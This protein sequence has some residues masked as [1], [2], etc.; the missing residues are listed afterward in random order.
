MD[1]GG[2][3][4]GGGGGSSGGGRKGKEPADAASGS[5][6]GGKARA[7]GVPLRTPSA[8]EREN[9]RQRERR[10]RSVAANI[11]FGLRAYG[12]YTLPRNC[13]NNEVL[14]A[15]CREAGWV[16]E[17]DGT[18]YRRVIPPANMMR[19]GLSFTG[20]APVSPGSSSYPITPTSNSR[21]ASSSS[22]HRTLAGS[23]F[24]GG[25]T[26]TTR[27]GGTGTPNWYKRRSSAL[28]CR[29]REGERV[30]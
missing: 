11:Y 25:A 5:G 9:N 23:L 7:R 18:T 10:R 8:E 21:T 16:V 30:V 2:M 27:G 3:G 13:D 29:T 14:K 12:N 28:D 24:N 17:P 15:L 6:S 4:A 22:S 20:S 1:G 19:G 26:A